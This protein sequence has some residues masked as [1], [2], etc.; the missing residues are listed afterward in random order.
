MSETTTQPQNI[1]NVLCTGCRGNMVYSPD[2][3]MLEC[4]QC[5]ST[6]PI[7]TANDKV[8]ENDF[9][10]A[11]NLSASQTGFDAQ[12]KDFKCS[13]CGSVTSFPADTVS[14]ECPFCGSKNVDPAAHESRV[15]RPAALIPFKVNK[16]TAVEKFK[17]WIGSG[18]FHPN[19]LKKRASMDRMH[20]VYLPYWTY[21]AMTYSHWTAD[22]G[23]YYYTT[24]T[25]TDSNGR[26]QTRQVRHV[27]WVPVS[28]YHEYFFDDVL[29]V[30]SH[31]VQQRMAEKVMPFQLGELVNYDPQFMLGMEAEVYQKDV[32]Q[33]FTVAEGIMASELERQIVQQIPGDTHRF[34]NINTRKSN[35]TF[36]HILLPSWIS[37]YTYKNKV[38]QFLV[39]GQTG[40]IGGDKPLSFWKIFFTV[41]AVVA[42]GVLIWYFTKK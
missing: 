6:R 20:G 37:S 18:W 24:E 17:D 32:Q 33:G 9:G 11:L 35:I 14:F 30:A 1:V 8:V 2:K 21:D 34:L 26:T 22:A 5:G 36:K 40:A 31:G 16:K 19:D 13:A 29:V 28:G 39:N 27:R 15:I 7:P 38:Y 4:P 23:Y 41:L 25:Y 42:V 12:S 10:T 3:Q